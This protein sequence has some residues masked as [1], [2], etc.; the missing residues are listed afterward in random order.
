MSHKLSVATAIALAASSASASSVDDMFDLRGY[1]TLGFVHSDNDKADFVSAPLTQGKGAGYTDSWSANVDSRVGLQLDANFTDR[2]S[3]VVQ[4][5]SESNANNTWDGDTNEDYRPSLEWAN[6]SYRVTDDLTV[7]AGRIVLPFLSVAEFRKV[8]F[9]QHW[10]RPP[11]ETYGNVP[12][13]SSDG[14]DVTYRSKVGGAINTVR[15]HYGYQPLRL[16]AIKAQVKA[17]GVNDTVEID[18]LTLRAAY[19][20]VSVDPVAAGDGNLEIKH[21]G[22]GFTYDPSNWFVMGEFMRE[23]QDSGGGT[24]SGYI[25]GG[26]RIGK[27]TPYA[28]YSTTKALEVSALSGVKDGQQSVGLGLRWDFM[29]NFALKGQYD[30]ISLDDGSTGK[31]TNIQPGFEL[32]GDTNL[33]SVTLDYVF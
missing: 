32:G 17:W 22:A 6:L 10:V 18:A 9:A 15:A 16:S 29:G 27:F 3:A 20:L 11:V 8:G 13:T 28:T 12:F 4:I 5:I 1:G 24:D 25:S 2:F 33:F 21:Y 23:E 7:R 30:Q 31:F 26:V 19:M 14:A